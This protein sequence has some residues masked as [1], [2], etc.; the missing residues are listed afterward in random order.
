MLVPIHHGAFPL[1][2]E[3]LDEPGRWLVELATQR[4]LREHVQMM[5]AGQ[6]ERFVDQAAP[7]VLNPSPADA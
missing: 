3:R 6:T 1:S 2:Y 7:R 5:T 4:G